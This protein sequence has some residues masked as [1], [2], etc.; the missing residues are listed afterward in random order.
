MANGVDNPQLVA[1]LQELTKTLKGQKDDTAAS[2]IQYSA[3]EQ[4]K[5]NEA[6]E[7][8]LKIAEKL[9]KL[10]EIKKQADEDETETLERR[11]KIDA[12][13]AKQQQAQIEA[14]NNR[15][16]LE[17]ESIKA[18]EKLAKQEIERKRASEMESAGMN[19]GFWAR[20]KA[21]YSGAPKKKKR[22]QEPMETVILESTLIKL[23]GII[24]SFVILIFKQSAFCIV[25]FL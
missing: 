11:Q 22:I 23:G 9:L 18:N 2:K 10:Q 25:I 5:I 24:I 15:K 3:E 1:A 19:K 8:E 14:A 16:N 21:I 12:A 13:I 7:K 4:N 6:K 20:I 17:I